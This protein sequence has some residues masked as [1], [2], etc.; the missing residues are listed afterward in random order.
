LPPEGY[1][2]QIDADGVILRYRDANGQRYGRSTLDQ[3]RQ[4]AEGQT[5]LPAL[6]IAD[7]PDFPVRGFLLD[8]SRDRVP[9]RATLERLVGLLA[10]AR[11]NQLQLY[12]EHTFAYR[13]HA[14][15]W[16]DASP[17]TAEDVRWLDQ[18]CLDQGIEL[19]PNQNCFGHMNRWLQ[20]D[21]YRH[22]GEVLDG[23]E[24]LPGVRLPASVLAPTPANAR[25]AH[26]LF[27]EL[28]PNFTSRQVNV[29]CDEPFEL[30]AGASQAAVNQRGKAAVF[31]E[32]VGRIVDPLVDRGYQVQVCADMLRRSPELLR[33]LPA[34]TVALA[35][36]YEA[37]DGNGNGVRPAL[38]AAITA[39]VVRAGIDL[40]DHTDFASNVAPLADAGQP[41]WVLPG[42]SSWNSLVGRIDNA[43]ANLVDAAE[44][45][46][47]RGA[48]GYLITDW[49]DNGHL[50]PP[51][52]SFG[53][54]LYGGAVSWSLAAN[55]DLDRELP[56]LLDRLVF[57][58]PSGTVGRVL[59][60]LGRVWNSTGQQAFNCSPLQAALAPHQLHLV[61]GP[62]DTGKV[63]DVV[64]RIDEAVATL[65]R[66]TPACSDGAVVC[67]ELRTAARLSCHGAQRLLGQ[68]ERRDLEEAME[69]HRR[70]WQARSRPGGLPDSLAHLQRTLDAYV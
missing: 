44:V 22:R 25:F 7:W 1:E 70:C 66:A 54:L 26:E 56:G 37:P 63:H 4:Q 36:T 2:L 51:S 65:D 15:V 17:L 45:G 21:V 39:H 69:D 53:P 13:A 58:D 24:L 32:H 33:Q 64:D 40:A 27:D 10:L 67:D 8:I 35:W 29:G 19:V 12:T 48:S 6:R 14:V 50:Q 18:L 3:I 47:D 38:P 43:V 28:L 42:T 61:L 49:G 60:D 11:I 34:E 57:L 46:L 9:T 31:F 23:Y 30:G 55:R 16:R 5:Q 20:H 59:D 52:V 62:P 68:G 41:F